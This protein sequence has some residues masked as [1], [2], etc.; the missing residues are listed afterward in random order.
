ME[1]ENF[2]LDLENLRDFV[3]PAIFE[4]FA[5]DATP[6]TMNTDPTFDDHSLAGNDQ[7]LFPP[8]LDDLDA[9]VDALLLA[10]ST[11]Y[12]EEELQAQAPKRARV[13]LAQKPSSNKRVFGAQKTEQEIAKAKLSAVPGATLT[14]T[15]YCVRIWKGVTIVVQCTE[16]VSHVWRS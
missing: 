13:D 6:A 14:D 1:G 3:S 16:I 9:H 12:E 5:S 7:P 10:C 2:E 4:F 11:Q 8:S 15:N